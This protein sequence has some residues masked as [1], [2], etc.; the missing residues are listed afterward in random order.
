VRR[1]RLTQL[2][3]KLPNLALM[4]LAHYHRD[5]GDEVYLE[6][7]P[8]QS[9]FEE[10]PDI[11]YASAIFTDS[12]EAAA[13]FKRAFPTGFVSGTGVD[14]AGGITVEEML[15]IDGGMDGAT[16][17]PYEHYDYS[18]YPDFKAS[19]GFTQRGCRL[20][21]GFCGVH[22][23]EGKAHSVNAIEKIWR[24]G[25]WP[26]KLHLLDNDFFG[27]PEWRDR[28]AEIRDGGFRV[29]LSQGINI[30][31]INEEQARE[32]ATVEYRDTDFRER[33]LYTAWDNIGHEKIFFRGVDMLEACGIPPTQLM[34]Y[35]L[36]N[37]DAAE[38]WE[39]RW[40]RFGK[41]VDRGIRPYVM[42]FNKAAAPADIVCWQRWVNTG[43]SRHDPLGP[44]PPRD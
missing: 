13:A 31:L 43:L 19:I 38:T 16:A 30:R 18:I 23:K 41:M 6:E 20:A 22:G 36:V 1:V 8:L 27:V 35:M 11:A 3:G 44:V 9:M 33:R 34:V 15:G 37:Y 39:R 4:K 40:Y 14:R 42:V 17:W 28:I 7:S 5:Q 24:G 25:R 21:C 2:D 32:L 29:C 26:K 12:A 10:R